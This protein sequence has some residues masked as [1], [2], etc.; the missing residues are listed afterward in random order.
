MITL[1]PFWHRPPI[2]VPGG[3]PG[4]ETKSINLMLVTEKVVC[5]C[6]KLRRHMFVN[7]SFPVPT[8]ACETV[9]VDDANRSGRRVKP[10]AEVKSGIA[11]CSI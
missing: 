1:G 9:R 7:H 5:R 8:P 10:F 6:Q 11:T 2:V 3:I 4:L